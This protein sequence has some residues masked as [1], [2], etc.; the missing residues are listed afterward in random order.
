M[1]F[2]SQC[3]K[4]ME[5]DEVFCTSCGFQRGGNVVGGV[6]AAPPAS[7]DMTEIKDTVVGMIVAP[8]STVKASSSNT[9]QSSMIL[10][11][12]I[13]LVYGLLSMWATNNIISFFSSLSLF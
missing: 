13:V 1:A 6:N 8:A 9:L 7:F 3:G 12:I 4:P 2:C 11:V 5:E 10:C